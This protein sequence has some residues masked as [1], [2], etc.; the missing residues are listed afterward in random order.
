MTTPCGGTT[1]VMAP[2]VVRVVPVQRFSNE[3]RPASP[4]PIWDELV[5]MVAATLV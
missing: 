4:N 5:E 1:A 2:V 3:Y